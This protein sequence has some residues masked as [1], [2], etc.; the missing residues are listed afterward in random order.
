MF[1]NLRRLF[2]P[3]KK[4]VKEKVSFREARATEVFKQ[5]GKE[6]KF[7]VVSTPQS[8]TKSVME[9]KYT[10]SDNKAVDSY[11]DPLSPLNPM[12][13]TSPLNPLNYQEQTY[14]S[15]CGSS[16]HSTHSFD[17]SHSSSY[18]SGSC[19][20]SYDSGSSSSSSDF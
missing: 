1:E 3:K 5:K 20:S 8:N 12:S 15:D 19:S 18:D 4:E 14:K 11:Y 10:A 13:I 16:H 17:H 7:T 2:R 6:V 9:S